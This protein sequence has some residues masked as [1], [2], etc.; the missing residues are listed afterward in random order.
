M[1][2]NSGFT[3][4]ETLIY[5]ALFGILMAA[6]GVATYAIVEAAGRDQ[7]RITSQEEATFL[8]AKLN[9]ALTGA[10]GLQIPAAGIPAPSISIS[11][12]AGTTP[13]VFDLSSNKL[14][15]KE[16]AGTAT[17]LNSANVKVVNLVF[18]D[19]PAVGGKPEGVTISFTIRST[20]PRGTTIDQDFQTTKYLR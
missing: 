19:I 20:T 3:L 12:Y 9:W 7:T 2:K 11:K 10:N 6:V 1:Q 15:V 4:I 13:V 16:G 8:L 5:L 14:Q 18:T 17:D